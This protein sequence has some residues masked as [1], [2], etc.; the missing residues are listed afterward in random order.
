M[1]MAPAKYLV[2]AALATSLAACGGGS[3]GGSVTP[4]PAPPPPPA[5]AQFSSFSSVQS[6]TS[7]GVQGVTREGDVRIDNTGA[8]LQS[9]VATPVEGTGSIT[10]SVNNSREITSLAIS[11]G[12]SSVTFNAS[13]ATAQSLYLNGKPV[14]V[15]VYNPT[16][17]N[18]AIYGDPY[19]LGFNYQS[20]G[21]W[22]TG[23]VA[24]AT[25]KFGAIS[26]GAR[27]SASAIPTGG[28]AVYRGYVG[29]V[30]T[31][32]AVARYAAD[33]TFNVDFSA[34]SVAL[35][36]NNQTL[37]DVNTNVTMPTTMLRITGTMNYGAGSNVFSGSLN[38]TGQTSLVPLT[39]TGSG[40]FYGPSAN[41]LG[42]TF[43]LRGSTTTL[44]G[45]FGGKQ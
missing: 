34:R 6:G 19:V 37:T 36:T 7:I 22:G 38:A 24:G 18:Q 41:E 14:A 20:F 5:P 31:N 26:V 3:S 32:G 1:N 39:G 42:G 16:G 35:T 10:F 25:G 17:S 23:L 4:I 21:V 30:Y 8:I 43:F 33:A 9:G 15:A 44:I 28:T 40:T 45:G 13:N 29:G 11:G 2:L 27:S 12:Q